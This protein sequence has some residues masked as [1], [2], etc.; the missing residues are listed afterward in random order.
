MSDELLLPTCTLQTAAVLQCCSAAR[1]G[2]SFNESQITR[3]AAARHWPGHSHDNYNADFIQYASINIAE[4]NV[5]ENM[6]RKTFILIYI[7][8]A[9]LGHLN[10]HTV[11]CSSV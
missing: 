6:K 3:A 2:N 7:A 1:R 9:F 4:G 5:L 11:V 10:M 8:V